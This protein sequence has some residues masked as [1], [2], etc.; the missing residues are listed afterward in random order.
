MKLA[1]AIEHTLVTRPSWR[2][3][4]GKRTA[5]INAGHVLRILGGDFDCSKATATDLV[6]LQRTLMQEMTPR[7]PRSAAG[8]NRILAAATVILR[9]V[10]YAGELEH[11]PSVR[12]LKEPKG[13]LEYYSR[14]EIEMMLDKAWELGNFEVRDIILF[15][16]KTGCRQGEALALCA[17]DVDLVKHQVTFRDTKNGSDHTISITPDVE[18]MLTCRVDGHYEDYPVFDF[19]NKD[20]LLREF[21]KVRNACGI[22]QDKL[23]HTIRHSTGTLLA[24]AGVP[25]RTIMGIL[26]HQN[27]NTTLRYAKAT[28]KS[29][30]EALAL[31]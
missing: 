18:E 19:V 2:E 22:S 16:Y 25:I 7:G 15:C 1:A 28:D 5:E 12:Q 11:V 6:R 13:R 20:Q 21:K 3:G 4:K 30:E 31:L 8:I 26:N 27:I 9:E 14:E 17:G 24:E 10:H 29:K 23:F